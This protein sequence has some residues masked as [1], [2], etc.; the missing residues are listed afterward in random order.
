[1]QFLLYVTFDSSDLTQYASGLGSFTGPLG[2][3][4]EKVIPG[5]GKGE[6]SQPTGGVGAAGVE[7]KTVAQR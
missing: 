7:P 4:P 2:Q 1:M 6:F 3:I 5:Y